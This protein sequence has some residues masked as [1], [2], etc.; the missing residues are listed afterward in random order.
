M[1]LQLDGNEIAQ[2]K[3]KTSDD[4]LFKETNNEI[5]RGLYNISYE[6]LSGTA[7]ITAIDFKISEQ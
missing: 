1:M 6:L 7:Y 5:V 3:Y 2:L 4:I